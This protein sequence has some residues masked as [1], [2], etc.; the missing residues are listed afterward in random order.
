M[1]ALRSDGSFLYVPAGNFNGSDSFTYKARD[2]QLDSALAT[3]TITVNAVNDVAVARKDAYV[4]NED[5]VLNVPA[6]GVLAITAAT[7]SVTRRTTV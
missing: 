3:V 7:V 6:Q 2:G 4:I 5:T 1:V